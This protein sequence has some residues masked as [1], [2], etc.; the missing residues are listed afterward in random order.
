M[1]SNQLC[2]LANV[3]QNAVNSDETC[4]ESYRA[5]L[6]DGST[7]QIRP[8]RADDVERERDFIEGLS[9]ESRFHRFL[10]GNFHPSVAL[11]KRLTDIDHRHD[12]AYVALAERDGKTVQIGVSRFF[13]DQD[14]NSAEFAIA[15]AD[16]WQHKG[17]ATLLMEKLMQAAKA[18]GIEKLYSIDAVENANMRDFAEHMGFARDGDPQDHTRVVHT[19]Y[20]R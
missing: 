20:L 12:E 18:R 17:L 8:I 14:G 6:R 15:V 10:S 4:N 13:A 1:R 9:P 7:I 2:E 19:L 3:A 11:L 5:M 16:A